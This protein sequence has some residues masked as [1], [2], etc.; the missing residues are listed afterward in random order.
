MTTESKT[1]SNRRNATIGVGAGLLAGGAIGL[2][3]AMPGFSSAADDPATSPAAAIVVEQD[4]TVPTDAERPEPG[5]KLREM[6]QDLVDDGTIT[7]DQADAVADHLIENRPDKGDHGPRHG[8]RGHRPG[9]DGEVVAEVI[10]VDAETIRDAVRSGSSLAD[11]ATE[12]GVDPQTLIDAIVADAQG[13]LDLAVEN[14][15]LTAE[16]AADKAAQLEERITAMVNGERPEHPQRPAP[17]AG[18]VQ[19]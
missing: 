11:V 12:N 6:L 1:P 9:F 18:D 16:E 4:A 5:V 3:V 14:G 8:R 19:G 10:G 15:R 17:P 13:H 7:S 2:L